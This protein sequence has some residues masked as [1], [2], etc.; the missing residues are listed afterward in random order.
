M[1]GKV[2][3]LAWG[4]ASVLSGSSRREEGNLFSL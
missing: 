1:E 3:S 4:P 2:G